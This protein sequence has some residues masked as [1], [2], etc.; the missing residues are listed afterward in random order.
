V[1]RIYERGR[2]ADI[3]MG[4]SHASAQ[5]FWQGLAAGAI[6][7]ALVTGGALMCGLATWVKNPDPAAAFGFGK[8][9]MVAVLLL[10]GAVGEELMFR[11]YA[12]Q[13]L[14]GA[15]GLW[16]VTIPF[17]VLFALM[18][19]GNLDIGAPAASH[20]AQ[21]G[22]NWV[23]L[24]SAWLGIVNTGLWGV[25]FCVAMWRSGALWLPI[26]LH[27]G[28]NIVLP[29]AGAR[30]SGFTIVLTGYELQWTSSVWL[31]GGEY[32]P[33]ASVL[34]TIVCGLLLIWL[35]RSRLQRQPS[36]LL[37]AREEPAL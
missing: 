29:L 27:F 37:D 5:Q 11:G 17:A 6:S 34:T 35:W 26:G 30:L 4:W 1:V 31:S 22:V 13:L 12:F 28:W 25:L 3:G 36:L 21:F 18:H 24:G 19:L 9:A 32:G 23:K 16:R 8:L 10:F 15:F 20:A 7:A 14:A 2:L 33:E